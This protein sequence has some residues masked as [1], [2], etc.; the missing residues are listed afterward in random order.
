MWSRIATSSRRWSS[1]RA[2]CNSPDPLVYPLFS[3]DYAAAIVSAA[4]FVAPRRRLA[5]LRRRWAVRQTTRRWT[6]PRGCGYGRRLREQAG[7]AAATLGGAANNAGLDITTRLRLR[8]AVARA[9]WHGC[10]DAGRCGKQRGA[11]HHHAAA[12]TDGRCA[13]RLARLRRR[14]AVRQTTRGWTSEHVAACW[15]VER[16]VSSALE[17]WHPGRLWL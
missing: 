10:G 14:W 13:W 15:G 7:T 4:C 6:S 12:A 17:Y 11:G 1:A 5:R 2:S 9:G 16:C 8:T 3:L